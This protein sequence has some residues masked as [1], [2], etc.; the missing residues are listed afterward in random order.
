MFGCPQTSLSRLQQTLS[1]VCAC[2]CVQTCGPRFNVLLSSYETVLKDRS[3]LK[4]L[5]FEVRSGDQQQLSGVGH[6]CSRMLQPHVRGLTSTHGQSLPPP[7]AVC[8][9][10]LC[11][12]CAVG[13]HC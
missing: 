3:E 1:T 2:C 8:V 10:V 6:T 7:T 13:A 12:C 11:L 4:K 9:R 5:H